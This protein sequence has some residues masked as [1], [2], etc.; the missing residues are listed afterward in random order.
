MPPPPGRGLKRQ[1]TFRTGMRQNAAEYDAATDLDEILNAHAAFLSLIERQAMLRLE[2]EPT[3]HALKA[4][5]DTILQFA[6]HQD[7]LYMPLLEQKAAAKQHA[8]RDGGF[9]NSLGF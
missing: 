6:R 5:F 8:A 2:D 4:L 3:H 9:L 7:V 1:E